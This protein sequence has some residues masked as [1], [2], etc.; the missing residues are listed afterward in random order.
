MA[1]LSTLARMKASGK[2]FTH[3]SYTDLLEYGRVNF[4]SAS[5]FSSFKRQLL[6]FGVDFEAKRQDFNDLKEACKPAITHTLDLYT[7]YASKYDRFAI[8]DSQ[9]NGLWYGKSFESLE[10]SEGEKDAVCK[11]IYLAGKTRQQAGIASNCLLLTVYTDAEWLTY[12]NN[13]NDN[14]AASLKY[15]AGKAGIEL[16]IVHIPGSDNPADD[17]TRTKERGM[18]CKSLDNIGKVLRL[19]APV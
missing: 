1:K 7:D 19:V 18:Y 13:G 4:N 2:D 10:Q 16:D 6:A 3:M 12:W 5:G 8:T 11:A 14:K 9:G 15:E 17:L